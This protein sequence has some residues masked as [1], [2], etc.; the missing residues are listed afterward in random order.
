[1]WVK[2]SAAV[3]VEM[4]A[5]DELKPRSGIAMN[6][7]NAFFDPTARSVLNAAG[8][9]KGRGVEEG[10]DDWRKIWIDLATSSGEL[11]LVV[12]LASRDGPEFKGDGRLGLTF[13][14]LEVAPRN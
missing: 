4:Q 10:P 7:G 13:G 8:L 1:A 11:V 3:K 14:G 12:G 5:S 9:I 6:Y 2:G